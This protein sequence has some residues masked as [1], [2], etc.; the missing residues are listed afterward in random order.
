LI[1]S[2]SEDKTLVVHDRVAGKKFK[3]VWMRNF[4][5]YTDNGFSFFYTGTGF[6]TGTEGITGTITVE[7]KTIMNHEFG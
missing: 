4:F 3:T 1:Y 5:V 6:G 2:L 7:K